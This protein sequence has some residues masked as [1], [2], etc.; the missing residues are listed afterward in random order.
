M[1]ELDQFKYT[2]STYDETLKEVKDSLDLENKE[3]RICTASSSAS[4]TIK[5]SSSVSCDTAVP[6]CRFICIS[7]LISSIIKNA[8]FQTARISLK[9]IYA[10]ERGVMNNFMSG[11]LLSCP[12]CLQFLPQVCRL[13]SKF[14]KLFPERVDL[15]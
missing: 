12:H 15:L 5:S 14:L 1:V 9:E 8:P 3:R 10:A 2:L 11:F 7:F 4:G 13:F 6:L